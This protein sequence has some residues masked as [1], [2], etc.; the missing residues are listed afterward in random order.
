M[1]IKCEYD[2]DVDAVYLVLSDKPYAYSKEVDG[3]RHID[4]AADNTPVG[5]ELLCVSGG[6]ILEDLPNQD[7]IAQVLASHK[8]K[9][10]A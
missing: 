6:V 8:I 9:V 4:Y 2:R 3:T 1:S 10:F 5:V 7:E